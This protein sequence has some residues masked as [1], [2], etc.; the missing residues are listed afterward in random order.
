MAN[1][2]W[3]IYFFRPGPQF[4]SNTAATISP[5]NVNCMQKM[6][7]QDYLLMKTV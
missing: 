5:H 2:K 7:L 1:E 4:S 6:G 3:P